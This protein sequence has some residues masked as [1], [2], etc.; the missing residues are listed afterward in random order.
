MEQWHTNT[1][2]ITFNMWDSTAL[3]KISVFTPNENCSCHFTS[4]I[5]L[6]AIIWHQF[7]D[8]L[9]LA[10]NTKAWIH[11]IYK[12]WDTV[13]YYSQVY[14]VTT[15]KTLFSSKKETLSQRRPLNP[16]KWQ[17][18]MHIWYWALLKDNEKTKISTALVRPLKKKR[19]LKQNTCSCLQFC[20]HPLQMSSSEGIICEPCRAFI[21]TWQV[22]KTKAS[23]LD[24]HYWVTQHSLGYQVASNCSTARGWALKMSHW[25]KDHSNTTKIHMR[26]SKNSVPQ[27]R[28]KNGF[29]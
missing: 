26:P 17:P 10:K 5:Q 3:I 28:Y 21:Q 27:D 24:S 19:L 16:L 22:L 15:L 8:F 25:D 6:A 7:L 1:T 20:L 12:K 13:P 11:Q 23:S 4:E 14:Q 2:G 9:T 18:M 29:T